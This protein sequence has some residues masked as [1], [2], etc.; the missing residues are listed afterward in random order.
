MQS[1][2]QR[3][4]QQ[5]VA[6]QLDRPRTGNRPVATSS[7][8]RRCRSADPVSPRPTHRSRRCFAARSSAASATSAPS[9]RPV[10]A[11]LA[12]ISSRQSR[13]TCVR[14]DS[15]VASSPSGS[16]AAS[17]RSSRRNPGR[18]PRT[19]STS[20]DTSASTWVM[21]RRM[22][23]PSANSS[24]LRTTTVKRWFSTSPLRARM[25]S[26]TTCSPLRRLRG[27]QWNANPLR[28]EFTQSGKAV[29]TSCRAR[30]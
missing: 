25:A 26:C 8:D 3:H 22:V 7:T 29:P 16:S 6:A 23:V 12:S 28:S 14:N 13:Y 20:S 24:D 9:A 30:P 27:G 1:A 2:G 18:C 4:P 19:F 10:S 5:R 11:S 17:W 15:S 21:R